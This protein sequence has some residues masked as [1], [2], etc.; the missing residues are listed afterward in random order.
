MGQNQDGGSS[1]AAG[2]GVIN[3]ILKV[4]GTKI[5]NRDGREV[6]LK[7]VGCFLSILGPSI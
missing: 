7:G 3:S 2:S 1:E 6:V 5:V 4:S